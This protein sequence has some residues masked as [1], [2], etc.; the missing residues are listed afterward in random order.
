M[1]VDLDKEPQTNRERET[2]KNNVY[3]SL[4]WLDTREPNSN[5]KLVVERI[6]AIQDA[7]AIEEPKKGKK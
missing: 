5:S 3:E 1:N 7:P 2:L 6:Q 4:R